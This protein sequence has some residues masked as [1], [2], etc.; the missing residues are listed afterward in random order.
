MTGSEQYEQALVQDGVP[1][2]SSPLRK[3]ARANLD[4][5]TWTQFASSRDE[6]QKSL[7]VHG[8][9]R[10]DS[11][12]TPMYRSAPMRK[13]AAAQMISGFRL[14]VN[15]LE[16][17]A[18]LTQHEAEGKARAEQVLRQR[19]SA[20]AV[21]DAQTASLQAQIELIRQDAQEREGR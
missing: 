14:R 8:L 5:P 20:D 18:Q 19:T 10:V 16:K 6:L 13:Q 2:A 12:K 9:E 15:E 21:V 11:N 1:A 4:D 17:L 7:A 3:W